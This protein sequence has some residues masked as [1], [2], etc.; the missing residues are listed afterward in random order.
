MKFIC[1]KKRNFAIKILGFILAELPYE[2][3][4]RKDLISYSKDSQLMLSLLCLRFIT[5][6]P[7][8]SDPSNL[9]KVPRVYI[10]THVE[11]EECYLLVYR[12][13]SATVCLLVDGKSHSI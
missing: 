5:G 13:L 2:R 1:Q 3:T 11:D 8:L 10:N 9:G 6:P 4:H 12:A 7:S